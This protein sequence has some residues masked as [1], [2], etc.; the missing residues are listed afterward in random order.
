[1]VDTKQNKAIVCKMCGSKEVEFDSPTDLCHECWSDWWHA[2]SHPD[3]NAKW[4]R[5]FIEIGLP[6][7]VTGSSNTI[8]DNY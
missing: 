5:F 1:M 3:R 4:N 6:A 7:C 8:E 2:L